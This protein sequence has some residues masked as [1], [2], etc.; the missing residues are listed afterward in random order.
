MR[1]WREENS[2]SM[3]S[4]GLE[5]TVHALVCAFMVFTWA[6]I[7]SYYNVTGRYFFQTQH[8]QSVLQSQ[9]LDYLCTYPAQ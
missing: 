9:L 6:C 8:K 5:I 2:L 4:L 3:H 7:I 1:N